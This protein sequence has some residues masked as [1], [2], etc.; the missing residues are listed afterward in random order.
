MWFVEGCV[1]QGVSTGL[2]C[3]LT[4]N[5]YCAPIPVVGGSPGRSVHL[6]QSSSEVVQAGPG[7]QAAADTSYTVAPL[8]S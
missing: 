2:D 5:S 3:T 4:D 7:W 6:L 1:V 8:L